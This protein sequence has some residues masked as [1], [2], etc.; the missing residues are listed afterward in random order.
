MTQ[1]T[2]AV[3]QHI[4]HVLYQRQH[5][6]GQQCEDKCKAHRVERVDGQAHLLRLS[7]VLARLNIG[8]VRNVADYSAV[9]GEHDEERQSKQQRH[10][11][12]DVVEFDVENGLFLGAVREARLTRPGGV[13]RHKHEMVALTGANGEQQQGDGLDGD[14]LTA[15]PRAVKR[16]THG[17]VAV[18][19]EA[20][21]EP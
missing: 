10:V 4:R 11:V 21:D 16:M 2:E 6:I 8:H 12:P 18:D 20:D 14:S 7:I 15:Q 19:G 9:T 1:Q 3:Q 5:S 17:D 13:V